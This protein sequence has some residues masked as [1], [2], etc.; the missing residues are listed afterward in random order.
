LT[1]RKALMMLIGSSSNFASKTSASLIRLMHCVTSS[2]F[3]LLWNENKL[4]PFKPF[5]VLRQGDP[6]S[7]YLFILCVEKLFIAINDDVQKCNWDPFTSLTMAQ[8][9]L[10]FFLQ[11]MSSSS[12]GPRILSSAL[13]LVFLTAST[14]HQGWRSICKSRAFYSS[15][16]PHANSTWFTSI[17]GIRSIISFK[18]EQSAVISIL[19]LTRWLL[20]LIIGK[21]C[22]W[23]AGKIG[24]SFFCSLFHPLILYV[25]SLAYSKHL[26]Q[27]RSNN[28][29]L[30]LER[31]Q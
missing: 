17:T 28:M 1:L 26:R 30:H 3:S 29:K 31:C 9:F 8:G 19:L 25:D 7:P 5:H 10:A 23:K 24:S 20:D 4:P 14:V 11:M 2:T 13:S 6:L 27:H 18:G 16:T 15:G 22:F 21:I 12:P